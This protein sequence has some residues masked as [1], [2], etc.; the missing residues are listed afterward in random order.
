MA[1][2]VAGSWGVGDVEAT[3][4]ELITSGIAVPVVVCGRNTDLRHRLTAMPGLV[5]VGW[6]DAMHELM[7]AADVLVQNAGGLSCMEAFASELPAVSYRCIPGHGEHN[8]DVMDRIGVAPWVHSDSELT[9]ILGTLRDPIVREQQVEFAAASFR[10][11]PADVVIAQ[12]LG[13]DGIAF[14][15]HR[16]RRRRRVAAAL[17]IR[18]RCSVGPARAGWL[19]PPRTASASFTLLPSS[20]ARSTSSSAP[21][22]ATL[23]SR[24]GTGAAPTARGRRRR[25]HDVA[26][27]AGRTAP[28]DHARRPARAARIEVVSIGAHPS[29][30]ERARA[31]RDQALRAGRRPATGRDGRG[32]GLPARGQPGR[33]AGDHSMLGQG[34]FD[35]P[36]A[37]FWSTCVA[38]RRARWPPTST[39]LPPLFSRRGLTT[40]GLLE[41]RGIRT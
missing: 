38:A 40:H 39:S 30:A 28:A 34:R 31:D 27:P 25:S 5:A 21:T 20:R 3:A 14:S 33:A 17:G 13:S 16:Q 35:C 41:L 37:S 4:R 18:W 8:A 9:S 7:T 1:L 24:R 32:F 22:I 36:P 2:L 15:P 12:A 29:G 6:T 10:H 11:D 19:P 26:N 23:H